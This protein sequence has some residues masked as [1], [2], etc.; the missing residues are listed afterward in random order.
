MK[1][2]RQH[3]VFTAL[4]AGF[5][6]LFGGSLALLLKTMRIKAAVEAELEVQRE[7]RAALWARK[8]FPKQPNVEIVQRNGR[9]MKALVDGFLGTFRGPEIKTPVLEELVAKGRILVACRQMSEALSKAEVKHPEKFQF[10]FERYASY[11]PKKE[12]TPLLL[13][14]LAITEELMRLLAEARI[15][16]LLAVRRVEF[17]D[18]DPAKPASSYDPKA[19]P[20]ISQNGKFEFVNPPNSLYSTMPF[21]LEFICDTDALRKFLDGLSRSPHLLIPRII[22][23]ENEKKEPMS[24]VAAGRAAGE[25]GAAF[26]PP[27]SSP[28]SRGG[29]KPPVESAKATTV[30]DPSTIRPVMGEERIKVGIRLDWLDFRHAET[31]KVEGGTPRKERGGPR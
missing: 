17:E 29:A 22:T 24:S 9:E 11:P 27:P 26:A 12:F 5:L 1:F 15:H 18:A 3:P 19:D 2:I 6:L 31:T 14:Q 21:D 25:S 30:V 20:L 10:G 23:V 16:D 7:R 4:L 8:P 28:V 13:K